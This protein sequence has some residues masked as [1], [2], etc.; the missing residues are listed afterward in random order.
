MFFSFLLG[1]LA[2]ELLVETQGKDGSTT[3]YIKRRVAVGVPC[4]AWKI[5]CI[6]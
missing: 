3:I 6:E 1:K 2:I 4:T 5:S